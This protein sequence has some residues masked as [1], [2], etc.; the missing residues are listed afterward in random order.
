MKYDVRITDAATGETRIARE[1][2][3]WDEVNFAPH[4]LWSD[5]NYGCDCNRYLFFERAG[6]KDPDVG[7]FDCNNGPNRYT[8]VIT[9]SVNHHELYRDES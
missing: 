2:D 6:G 7:G 4:Y 1:F 8:V 5:G 3:D 9:D